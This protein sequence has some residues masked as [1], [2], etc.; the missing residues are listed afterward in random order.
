M[1]R[2]GSGSGC[3]F[4]PCVVGEKEGDC[5]IFSPT[6]FPLTNPHFPLICLFLLPLFFLLSF[7]LPSGFLFIPFRVIPRNQS[8]GQEGRL[9]A[10]AT[11]FHCLRT[12]D[13]HHSL[14]M[15]RKQA[16]LSWWEI[17][18][19]AATAEHLPASLVTWCRSHPSLHGNLDALGTQ[20]KE[21]HLCHWPSDRCNC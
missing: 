13:V 5:K 15:L 1:C 4:F 20:G 7:P 3:V 17:P 8:D 6:S 21:S 18:A 19:A 11:R 10:V 14:S 12:I 9:D 16:S 2:K